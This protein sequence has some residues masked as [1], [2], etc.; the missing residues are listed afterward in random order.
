MGLYN[1][2][3]ME[4]FMNP[5]NV[6]ELEHP[7]GTGTYGSPVCGDMMQIQINVEND[8]ITDAKFKTFGCGS[9][10]VSSSMATS[11]I[12]GKTIDEAL[13]ISNKQIIDELGGLPP[14][15]VHCSV[16]AD[17]AIKSAIYDYA[18]KNGKTYK[19]LEGFDPDAD[20]DDEHEGIEEE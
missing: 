12:I 1:D 7:D 9:A 14:V 10:I 19:G 8:I 3:V 13:E 5:R 15:K 20:D 2:T 6:G 17:H 16:L 4:H 11:M 18:Q